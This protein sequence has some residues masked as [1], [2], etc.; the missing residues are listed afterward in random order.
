MESMFLFSR[1]HVANNV[2][3]LINAPHTLV[4]KVNEC[5]LDAIL[6]IRN[7]NRDCSERIDDLPKISA[8]WKAKET[9]NF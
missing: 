7:E 2:I 3:E 8:K 1:S 5:A 9:E 6:F 4:N